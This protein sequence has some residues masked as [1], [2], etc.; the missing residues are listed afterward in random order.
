MDRA[1]ALAERGRGQT[2]PNPMV[3]AVVVRDDRVVGE[4][5]HERAGGPHAEL[6]ALQNAGENARGGT[7]YVTLEPCDHQGRTPPCTDAILS[8]GITR[9]VAAIADPNPESGKGAE[10]LRAA[11]VSIDLGVRRAEAFELNAAWLSSFERK[12]P[13]VTLKLAVSLDGA[14]ADENRTRGRFTGMPALAEAH[15]MRASHDAVAVGI[16]TAVA[17]DPSLTARTDPPP[18]RPPLRIVFDR[19]ARLPPAS[20][21]AQTAKELPTLLITDSRAKVSP[22][23]REAGVESVAATDV[24]A[25]LRLLH[26]RGIRSLLVEGGAG[27][28]ASFLA[29]GC[30]DRVVLFHAPLIFGAGS[31]GAFSGVAPHDPAHAPRFRLVRTATLGDDVMTVYASV[32]G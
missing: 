6:I 19:S 24:A 9:V 4:G 11:G 21:L 13:W 28:G 32:E 5:F 25:S 16:A 27:L 18:A 17:D 15:R 10:R 26:E 20:V 31:L 29:S 1:L 7:L 12:R 2:A 22:E 8:A 14:I 23:L 30:V 3:G